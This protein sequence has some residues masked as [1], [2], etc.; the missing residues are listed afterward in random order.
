MSEKDTWIDPIIH[1]VP[2]PIT[3]SWN[4]I[5]IKDRL[6]KDDQTV[7]AFHNDNCDLMFFED[8]IWRDR[9][10][11]DWEVSHWMPLPAAPN[12]K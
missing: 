2:T 11:I 9:E 7:L 1:T 4:W 12:E 6:P 5:S 10:Y 3:I 8:G